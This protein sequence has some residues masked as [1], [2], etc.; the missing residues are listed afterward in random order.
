MDIQSVWWEQLYVYVYIY[1]S[2]HI[3]NLMFVPE[4]IKIL[5][6]VYGTEISFTSVPIG[7]IKRYINGLVQD[8]SNSSALAMEL[9]PSCTKPSISKEK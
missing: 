1:I 6:F 2:A 7:Y 3:W 5:I 4:A 9:L 8:C